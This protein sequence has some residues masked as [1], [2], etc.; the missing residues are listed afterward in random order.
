MG[1]EDSAWA[2]N[3][4]DH[5]KSRFV[6]FACETAESLKDSQQLDEAITF[7]QACLDAEDL[8]E[9]IYRQLM[10]YYQQ[11]GRKAESIEIF[12]RCS[13]TLGTRLGVE[14]SA[15]TKRIYEDL[16]AGGDSV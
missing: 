9:G 13:N 10:L 12:N 16:M 5:W 15:E 4:R 8:A 11:L 7:L 6:R 1:D 2:I 3:A 14:P